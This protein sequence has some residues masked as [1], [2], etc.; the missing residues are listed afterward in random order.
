MVKEVLP[1]CD[2][3]VAQSEQRFRSFVENANDAFFALTS[4]GNYTYV[5]PQW[6][7]LFGYEISE[8]IGKSFV[9]FV[10]PDDLPAC[11]S[12]LTTIL[13]TGEKQRGVECRVLHKNGTWLWYSVNGSRLIDPDGT[14][15]LIGI[16]RDI[17]YNKLMQNELIRAQKLESLSILATGIA[18]NFNNV[19]TGVIGYISFARKH[20]NDHDKV[21]P[22]LEAAEKSSHRA[23]NLA[24]QLLTFSKGGVISK[25]S[26]S[27][28][29]LVQE[30]ISLY[31]MLMSE[32]SIKGVFDSRATLT[33]NVDSE[34]MNQAFNNIVLNSIYSMPQGGTLTVHIEDVRL[35]KD[36]GCLLEHGDYVKIVFED[37]GCGIEK[38]HLHKVFDPYFTTRTNG[39]GLGLSTTY[40]TIKTHGGHISVVSEVKHGTTVTV[41]LP[42]FLDVPADDHDDTE[43]MC[44]IL[45]A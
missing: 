6:K 5:S 11:I 23:A 28:E 37:S 7:E 10:H 9:P 2:N 21:A 38:K 41:I 15:S 43:K 24:R 22:L 30:S 20:L 16:G 18:H 26:S 3:A 35:K 27:V 44:R 14:V 32:S 33:V 8:V 25:K 4:S 34:Q 39:A 40:S 42:G 45:P 29:G 1:H 13:E 17:S 19:L 31:L 12:F 36:N